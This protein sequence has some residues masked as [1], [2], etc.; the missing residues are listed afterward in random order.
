MHIARDLLTVVPQTRRAALAGG[1]LAHV[2]KVSTGRCHVAVLN[3]AE[4]FS[5]A[6]VLARLREI[7]N[8]ALFSLRRTTRRIIQHVIRSATLIERCEIGVTRLKELRGV[9]IEPRR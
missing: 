3:S 4:E 1:S 6:N 5:A 2:H 8:A 7:A 9:W